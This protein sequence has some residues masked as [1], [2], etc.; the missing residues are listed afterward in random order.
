M[1]ETGYLGMSM[2]L[3]TVEV[4]YPLVQQASTNTNPTPAQELDPLLEPIWAQVSLANTDSLDLVF[5]SNEVVIEAMT[6]SD[7]TWE[8]I[9]HISYFLP[10]LSRIEAGEFTV[11]M[12]GDQSYPINLLVKHKIYAKG[13]METIAETI[14][15]NIFQNP[16]VM[17][18]VFVESY[19]SPEEIQIYTDLFK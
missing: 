2:P 3:F 11:T 19:F 16:G 6:S 4:V 8:Y 17:E 12:M 10:D 7:K 9:H 5:P 1:D 15:I 13:N 18:N 14:P